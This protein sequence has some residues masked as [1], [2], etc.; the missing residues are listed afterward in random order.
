MIGVDT[1][2]LI[3]LF[4]VD[5][6]QS[7][8]SAAFFGARSSADPAFV[9]VLVV[10]EFGWVLGKKYGFPP[11]RIVAAIQAMLDSDDFAFE[12]RGVVEWALAEYEMNKADLSDLLIARL[13]ALASATTTVT[14]D[15]RAAKH[16]SGMELLK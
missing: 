15:T 3:R 9:S 2:V 8:I 6:P 12:Q 14:F 5:E 1:N 10:A 7:R 4:I 13:A 16:I 11:E